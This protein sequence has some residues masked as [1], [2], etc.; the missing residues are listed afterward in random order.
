MDTGSREEFKH[1]YSPAV[2]KL[3]SESSGTT[4]EGGNNFNK[5]RGNI[6]PNLQKSWVDLSERLPRSNVLSVG[7]TVGQN[8]E[9][10][11]KIFMYKSF[12]FK[13]LQYEV[14]IS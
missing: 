3:P 7:E 6:D 1:C 9:A 12:V 13:V 11:R 5:T 2:H 4:Q 10:E 8:S 14:W